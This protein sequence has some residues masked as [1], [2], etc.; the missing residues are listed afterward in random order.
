MTQTSTQKHASWYSAC[1][2]FAESVRKLSGGAVNSKRFYALTSVLSPYAHAYDVQQ[3][4]N[5]ASAISHK[6]HSLDYLEDYRMCYSLDARAFYRAA[7]ELVYCI[8]AKKKYNATH[9]LQAVFMETWP[10][11]RAGL[12]NEFSAGRT[13]L[14]FARLDNEMNLLRV[15]C[16]AQEASS[17]IECAI[18]LFEQ[19]FYLISFGHLDEK[20]AQSLVDMAPT[21]VLM[22]ALNNDT[23]VQGVPIT[24]QK[25]ALMKTDIADG[26]EIQNI[27]TLS[28]EKPFVIG[29][30]TACDALET[31]SLV[32]RVHCKLTWENSAWYVRDEGS[33]LGTLVE[34]EQQVVWDSSRVVA[35]SAYALEFGDSIVLANSVRYWFVA[36]QNAERLV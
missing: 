14:N 4:K 16:L 35:G 7:E 30:Y 1:Y 31:N 24:T 18:R 26:S 34:R 28:A 32:S 10:A 22:N 2:A 25:A 12:Q 8:L 19:L 17:A 29:R 3:R 27:W 33:K 36:L 15:S 9:L 6:M 5:A 11:I 20:L 21:G 23:A 13:E